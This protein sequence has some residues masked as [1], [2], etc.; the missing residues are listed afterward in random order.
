MC[1]WDL[2]NGFGTIRRMKT[3]LVLYLSFCLSVLSVSAVDVDSFRNPDRSCRP[4][5][6]FHLIGGNVSKEGMDADLDAIANAGISGIHL[7][8]G[9]SD[10]GEWPNVKKQIPCLSEDWDDLI[11]FVADGCEKR[12]LIFKM[13]NC[14]GWS[15]SGGPW[16][17]PSNAMRNLTYSRTDIKGGVSVNMELPIPRFPLPEVKISDEDRDYRDLFVL[18]SDVFRLHKPH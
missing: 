15:M 2:L 4:E 7:F 10:H 6:W 12:G 18:S 5:T 11:R 17:A 1:L 3:L 16:I 14:P 9:R 8:H 13:Q